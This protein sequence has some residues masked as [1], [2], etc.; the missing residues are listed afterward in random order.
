M[1]RPSRRDMFRLSIAAATLAGVVLAAYWD[2][3]FEKRVAVVV[4]GR[5]IRGAWQ[6]PGPLRR[7]IGREKIRTIVTLTAINRDDPKYVEQDRVVRETGVDWVI[8]PMRGST[9]TLDQLVEAADLLADPA[10]GPVFFHC[11]AG[12]HRSNLVHAAYRIRHQGWSAERAWAEVASLPWARP[13]ARPDRSDRR[14][15]EAF[16]AREAEAQHSPR[17]DAHNAW[18]PNSTADP[19]FDRGGRP[20]PDAVHGLPARDGQLRGRDPRQDLSLRP[21]V[22]EPAGQ[23]GPAASDQDG[24]QPPRG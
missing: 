3:L 11:V 13:N 24:P 16:A 22:V 17:K 6:R 8:V 15:I 23:D 1:E 18:S 20:R 2:D 21:D 7:I 5:V 12:H 10:R 14:L 9:A 4:P 19:R